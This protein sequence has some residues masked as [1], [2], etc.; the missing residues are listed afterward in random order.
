MCH[1]VFDGRE[2]FATPLALL[3][4]FPKLSNTCSSLR[5]N[6]IDFKFPQETGHVLVHYLYTGRYQTLRQGTRDRGQ[7]LDGP[8]EVDLCVHRLAHVYDIAGLASMAKERVEHFSYQ[9]PSM[10][11]L[12]S[13][14]KVSQWL[15]SSTDDPWLYDLVR[16]EVHELFEE[17]ESLDRQGWLELFEPADTL[18]KML[19]RATMDE[20][21]YCKTSIWTPSFSSAEVESPTSNFFKDIDDLDEALVETKEKPKPE[22]EAR[23]DIGTAVSQ[24]EFTWQLDPFHP[25]VRN[26]F[27]TL[28]KKRSPSEH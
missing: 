6:R 19:C 24:S 3:K 21:C 5:T 23:Q 15:G 9:I 2:S 20:L 27:S 12:Q 17:S 8:L 25:Y 4:P 26:G 11:F 22:A 18:S 10:E 1:L 7:L 28:T 14:K 16:S 13:V